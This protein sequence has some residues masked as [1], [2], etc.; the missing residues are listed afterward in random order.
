MVMK[1]TMTDIPFII[2]SVFIIGMSL[3]LGYALL[4]EVSKAEILTNNT[5][6]NKT[7]NQAKF[8][9][10]VFDGA[11]L[12]LIIGFGLASGISAFFVRTHP[13]FFIF[14]FIVW[15]ISF[16]IAAIFSNIFAELAAT[17]PLLSI[18]GILTN[19]VL[20][21]TNF[22]YI[23]AL[24]GAIILIAMYAKRRSDKNEPY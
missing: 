1:A 16:V 23:V 3:F 12:F 11:M 14:S 24:I 20:V 9:Y 6:A 22:P 15:L 5:V 19:T 2:L 7:I 21:I 13:I 4:D 8:A 10:S 18:S 17:G